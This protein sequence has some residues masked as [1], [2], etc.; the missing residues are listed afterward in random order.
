MEGQCAGSGKCPRRGRCESAWK[1]PYP[2]RDRENPEHERSTSGM[3]PIRLLPDRHGEGTYP[4]HPRSI[5]M[6]PD[7]SGSGPRDI[8][9]HTAK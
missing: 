1:G 8:P 6:E 9:A 5:G 4:K 7:E 2:G 3:R